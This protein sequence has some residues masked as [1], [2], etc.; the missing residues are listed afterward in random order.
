MRKILLASLLLAATAASAQQLAPFPDDYRRSSCAPE[1]NC[2]SFERGR[3]ASAGRSFLGFTIDHEWIDA[4]WDELMA[5]FK[6][7]CAKAGTCYTIR[8]ATFQF[9]NDLLMPEFRAACNRFPTGSRDWEQCTMFVDTWALGRDMRSLEMWKTA[10]ECASRQP[11]APPNVAP[12]VWMSPSKIT[13]DYNDWI[14][15]YVV[16]PNTHLPVPAKL[17]VEG[18]QI[19]ASSNP[20]GMLWSYYPWKWPVKLNRVPNAQGHRDLVPPKLTIE[21]EGYLPVTIDMPFDLPKLKLSM[22]PPP[23]KIRRGVNIVTITAT[24]AA[25]GKPVELRVMHGDEV[26]GESNKPFELELKRGE[27]RRELW[28]TSLYNTYND[29]V[30]APAAGR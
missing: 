20:T 17:T 26:V 2:S 18:Q 6:P 24:D 16:D 11:Y 30:V 12:V 10:Q 27:K 7:V 23:D 29:V 8:N 9:C 19:Y 14:R 5:A 22:S 3:M 28:V 4:H 13:R 25:T 1:G 21:A 15:V